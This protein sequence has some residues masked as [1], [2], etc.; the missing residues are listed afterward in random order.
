VFILILCSGGDAG[1]TM[2]G[3]H[4]LDFAIHNT[5]PFVFHFPNPELK[6]GMREQAPFLKRRQAAVL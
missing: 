5:R 2:A 1:D 4:S 6:F 3:S